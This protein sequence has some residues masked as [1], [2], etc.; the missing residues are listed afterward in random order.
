M[1]CKQLVKYEIQKEK[2]AP[3]HVVSYEFFDNTGT[4]W[5]HLYLWKFKHIDSWATDIMHKGK[6]IKLG[7]LYV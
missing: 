6:Y 7:Q 4:N 5:N 1:N 2:A 3:G